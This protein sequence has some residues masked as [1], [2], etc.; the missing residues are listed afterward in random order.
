MNCPHCGKAVQ[1]EAAPLEPT[2][3]QR[4]AISD[5]LLHMR[6]RQARGEEIN[7][8]AMPHEIWRALREARRYAPSPQGTI[9]E[10]P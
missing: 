10:K 7:W 4:Q 2:K 9:K 6:D 5:L 1:P 3:E 8:L